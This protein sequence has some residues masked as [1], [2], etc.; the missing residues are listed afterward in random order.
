[1]IVVDSSTPGDRRKSNEGSGWGKIVKA[2]FFIVMVVLV[3]GGHRLFRD[4]PKDPPPRPVHVP[5]QPFPN[6][7]P[8]PGWIPPPMG[9]EQPGLPPRERPDLEEPLPRLDEVPPPR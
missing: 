1:V 6:Q 2:I 9:A 3:K 7:G 5:L 4:R 8:P